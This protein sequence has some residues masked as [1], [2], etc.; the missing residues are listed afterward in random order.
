MID[1]YQDLVDRQA[2]RR[3]ENTELMEKH[4]RESNNEQMANIL[5]QSRRDDNVLLTLQDEG[6]LEEKMELSLWKQKKIEAE[7]RILYLLNE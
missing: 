7:L 4:I 2:E 6:D 5:I 3:Q 1:E